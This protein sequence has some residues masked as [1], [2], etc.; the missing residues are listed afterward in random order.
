VRIE[1]AEYVITPAEMYIGIKV[2]PEPR[3]AALIGLTSIPADFRAETVSYEV[4]LPFTIGADDPAL[5]IRWTVIDLASGNVLV[6]QDDVAA[7]RETFAFAP[8]TVGAGLSQLRIA[9][10]VYRT[11]GSQ[12][13]DFFNDGISLQIR[14]PLSPGSYVRWYYDV[15]NPQVRFD[16]P[17]DAWA[18]IGE[19]VVRRHS[20]IHRTDRPCAMAAKHSRYTYQTDALDSLPFPLSQIGAHRSE[21]CDYCFYGGPA[22]LRPSL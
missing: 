21:L 16:E 5:R 18:F 1:I 14:P 6:N 10:R 4:R 12:I 19:T 9:V 11:L 2:K 20:N 15:K 7:G 8:E 13:T 3:P 17:S 22:G